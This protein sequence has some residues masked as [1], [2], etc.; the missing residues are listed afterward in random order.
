M[1]DQAARLI[2]MVDVLKVIFNNV[3]QFC[4]WHAVEAMSEGL[5]GEL[6]AWG[7]QVTILEPDHPIFNFPNQITN[8]DFKGWIQERNL[9]NF[10]TFDKQY[11]PMLES[12]DVGEQPNK[13]GM[14]YAK[15]GKGTYV[16]TSYSW[17]RQLPAGV[18]GAYRIF[19]NLL[20]LPKA[21]GK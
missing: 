13:G 11:V 1:G 16:Y 4:N 9:Y 20:S 6:A 19:A 15:I 10:V 7:V 5:A 17:F 8:D 3:L 21:A 2:K 14:V 18:P 12:H